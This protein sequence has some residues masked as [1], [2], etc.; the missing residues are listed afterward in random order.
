MFDRP[1]RAS[2]RFP[3]PFANEKAARAANN[4]AYP[5][6]LSVITKA[7][8]AGPTYMHALL[9]GY[10]E[11]PAGFNLAEGMYYNKYFPGHQIAMPPPLQEGQRRIRRRHLGDG[12]ADGARRD[13]V[14]DLGGRAGA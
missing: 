8:P 11:P 7:R 12:R 4:G 2:D 3:G 9:T 5:P 6:D 1:A 13:A 14:P 10:E